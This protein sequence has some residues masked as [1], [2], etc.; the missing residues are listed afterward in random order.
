M[1]KYLL[2]AFIFSALV[3]LIVFVFFKKDSLSKKSAT[4]LNKEILIE[5][6]HQTGGTWKEESNPCEP[7]CDYQRKKLKGEKLT[8]I[9]LVVPNCEC[10][11]DKCWNGSSCEPL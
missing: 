7:T 8:C 3:L 10:E 9:A 4:P 11:K 1:K 5:S 2:I 6:C